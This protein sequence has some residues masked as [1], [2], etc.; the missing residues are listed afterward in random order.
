L[1]RASA[2]IKGKID[3]K[4]KSLLGL[5]PLLFGEIVEFGYPLD[6]AA[7]IAGFSWHSMALA[8]ADGERS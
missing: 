7:K 2:L 3:I 4:H 1:N 5:M 6:S 8:R